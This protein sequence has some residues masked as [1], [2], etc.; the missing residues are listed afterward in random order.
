MLLPHSRR[1]SQTQRPAL[2]GMLTQVLDALRH[3]LQ[4]FTSGKAPHLTP[5]AER[6]LVLHPWPGNVRELRNEAKRLCA[7]G[8]DEI[9]PQDLSF[10]APRLGVD[11]SASGNFYPLREAIKQTERDHIVK[12]LAVCG[13]NKSEVA[14]LLGITRR[15]LYRRL[16]KYGI[17]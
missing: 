1:P 6:L 9:R 14:R 12:A 7:L 13:G 5:E 17:P 2:F 11:G 15:A 8:R 10:I 3:F 16:A 4:E